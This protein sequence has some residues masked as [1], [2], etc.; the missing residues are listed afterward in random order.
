[1]MFRM[2]TKRWLMNGGMPEVYA[3]I[4]SY[5]RKPY[6]IEHSKMLKPLIEMNYDEIVDYILT[7]PESNTLLST[8][9]DLLKR[10]DFSYFLEGVRKW[11]LDAIKRYEGYSEIEDYTEMNKIR[12]RLL[13]DWDITNYGLGAGYWEF[14]NWNK[15]PFQTK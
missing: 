15:N 6:N 5:N 12:F 2:G 13:Q 9:K 10:G 4:L 8:E 7:S 14:M 11:H 3:H 1:M